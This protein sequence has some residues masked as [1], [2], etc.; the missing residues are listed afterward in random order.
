MAFIVICGSAEKEI[1][2][3]RFESFEAVREMLLEHTDMTPAEVAEVLATGSLDERTID[4][5][6]FD[7]AWI[8]VQKEGA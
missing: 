1:S 6:Q 8:R 7:A 5:T 2:R 3:E 4:P